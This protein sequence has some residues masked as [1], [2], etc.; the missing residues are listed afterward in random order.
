MSA[1]PSTSNLLVKTHSMATGYSKIQDMCGGLN[2]R[3][4]HEVLKGRCV[5]FVHLDQRVPHWESSW[6]SFL[7]EAR[8]S[9][10]QLATDVAYLGVTGDLPVP[11]GTF[12]FLNLFAAPG[13]S[14]G[15][16]LGPKGV[17][18]RADEFS[19]IFKRVVG[20]VDIPTYGPGFFD[21]KGHLQT[22]RSADQVSGEG[23]LWSSSTYLRFN[24]CVS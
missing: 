6:S 3:T 4:P 16:T 21:F 18:L 12:I 15:P 24:P 5:L 20:Y 14:G 19:H 8:M 7:T 2:S 9:G 23:W 22:L 13:G 10:L 11:Q 1:L 17:M